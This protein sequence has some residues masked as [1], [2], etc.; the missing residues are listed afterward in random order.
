[1][2]RDYID[3]KSDIRAHECLALVSG[4]RPRKRSILTTHPL[5]STAYD[6]PQTL[7]HTLIPSPLGH[8]RPTSDSS[9]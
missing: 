8:D 7:T 3:Q 4:L 5:D 9:L 1:M 6:E 2:N